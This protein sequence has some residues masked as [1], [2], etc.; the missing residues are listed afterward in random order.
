MA[1]ES[2]QLSCDVFRLHHEVN[3]TGSD[4]VSRH[5]AEFCRF[6]VLGA[7]AAARRL[8]GPADIRPIR[9]R[10]G[11]NHADRLAPTLVRE[12]LKELI[13]GHMLPAGQHPGAQPKHAILDDHGG[14]GWNYIDSS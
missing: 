3:A 6:V 7:D 10:T 12:R 13:D 14:V 5:P 2:D 9:R 11:K 4:S 8:D 1:Y